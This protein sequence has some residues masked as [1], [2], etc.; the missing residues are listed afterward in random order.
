MEYVAEYLR[1]EKK[2]GDAAA[3]RATEAGKDFSLKPWK[4]RRLG[5]D[6]RARFGKISF[7]GNQGQ[8]I[9]LDRVKNGKEERLENG[10]VHLSAENGRDVIVWRWFSAFVR[11]NG[12]RDRPGGIAVQD[13]TVGLDKE[14]TPARE[15]LLEFA[16]G[17]E[18]FEA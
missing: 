6:I 16:H 9:G 12:F 17:D 15:F 1:E 10:R 7:K 13:G 2:F 14:I 11:A 5:G 8:T 4:P 18:L 3:D